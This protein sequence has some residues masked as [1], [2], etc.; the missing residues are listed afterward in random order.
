MDE[1]VL[2]HF[3][4]PAIMNS[5]LMPGSKEREMGIFEQRQ[6]KSNGSS[7]HIGSPSR[8]LQPSLRFALAPDP[9]SEQISPDQEAQHRQ[10]VP[11][12]Y[13]LANIPVFPPERENTTGMPDR[14]KAGIEN[15]SGL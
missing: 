6:R 3:C 13:S 8:H 11:L 4:N 5:I 1:L 12:R 15:L 9:A 7:V 10:S 14:L 2:I